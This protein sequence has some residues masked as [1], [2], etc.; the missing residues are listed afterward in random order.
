MLYLYQCDRSRLS[1]FLAILLLP[2]LVSSSIEVCEYHKCRPNCICDVRFDD[3]CAQDYGNY[4][5]D[6]PEDAGEYL[7]RYMRPDVSVCCVLP[8]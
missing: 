6:V 3:I 7:Y 4:G 8:I 2:V 1:A 5:W